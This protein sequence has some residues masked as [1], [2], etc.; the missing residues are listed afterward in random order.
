M[1]KSDAMQV[2]AEIDWLFDRVYENRGAPPTA[3]LEIGSWNG[4]NLNDMALNCAP[5]AIIRCIDR[6]TEVTPQLEK[7][8][9]ELN[10]IG[11]DAAGLVM[12]SKDPAA[13]EWADDCAPYDLIFI[14]GDHSYE[15]VNADWLNFLELGHIIA[16]H[17]IAGEE[18]VRR[19]WKEI[20]VDGW[21]TDEIITGPTMGIGIVYP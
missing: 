2:P 4:S 16:F 21:K 3:I 12:D 10:Q 9:Y 11:F 15:G 14:D 6:G 17:D 5:S 7:T 1:T 13:V 19:L 20:K 18:G 8:I